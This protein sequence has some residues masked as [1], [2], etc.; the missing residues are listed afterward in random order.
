MTLK[1]FLFADAG[2]SVLLHILKAIVALTLNWIVLHHF[3]VHDFVT[4]S[5]T[6]SILMVATASDLGIGQ[7]VV[8]QMINSPIGEWPRHISRGVSALLPMILIAFV[9]VFVAL[10]GS[11]PLY[12]LAMAFLL[13]ARILTIPFVAVLHAMNQ[14]KIRK[15]IELVAYMMALLLVAGLAFVG[16][17]VRL[18][19][20]A[21]NATFLMGTTMMLAAASRYVP[22]NRSLAISPISGTGDVY[23]SAIPFM[24]NNLTGLLTYGGFMWLSSLA[25]PQGDVAKLAIL[26]SFVLVNIY[27][28]YDVFLKARQ[29]D[30]ADPGKLSPY[31]KLNLLMMISLPPLFFLAGRRAIALIDSRMTFHPIE[32]ALF[33]LFMAL[34]LGNLFAQSITQVNISLA[35]HLNL[36]SLIKSVTLIS[37]LLESILRLTESARLPFLL[38]M[39]SIG[40]MAAFCYLTYYVRKGFYGN[41]QR[42]A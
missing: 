33:G 37:F 39:L 5:V 10:H 41:A 7:Y 3:A 42:A 32:I 6:S 26:H 36:Y 2:L 14:F 17:D 38:G 24:T 9:F 20:L 28:M 35:K 19:L 8:T 34:E 1:R 31:R 11:S 18:A 22:L 4:W 29:A 21:L 27:Q 12:R 25:L 16:A 13:A 15:A 23:R 30:L 40:S